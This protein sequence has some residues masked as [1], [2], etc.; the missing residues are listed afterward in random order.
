MLQ[1]ALHFN[2]TILDGATP[3]F[4]WNPNGK[5]GDAIGGND[6]LD[7]ATLNEAL[8]Q[9]INVGSKEYDPLG[10][11]TAIGSGGEDPNTG[12]CGPTCDYSAITNPLVAGKETP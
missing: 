8:A 9:L 1:A 2:I 3:V 10:I 6:T 5:I 7:D 11:H 4:I 12:I